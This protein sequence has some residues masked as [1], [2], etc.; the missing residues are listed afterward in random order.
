MHENEEYE[1][2]RDATYDRDTATRH[3]DELQAE[4]DYR[5]ER[6]GH[7]VPQSAAP[8]PAAGYPDQPDE[9]APFDPETGTNADE[10]SADFDADADD[11]GNVNDHVTVV[12]DPEGETKDAA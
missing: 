10:S 3:G 4:R 7:Q 5:R 11:D 12:S 1:T 6:L 8:V 2:G 9:P